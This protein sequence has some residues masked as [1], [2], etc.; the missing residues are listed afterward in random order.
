MEASFGDS[1]FIPGSSQLLAANGPDV[2][3][4]SRQNKFCLPYVYDRGPAVLYPNPTD[5]TRMMALCTLTHIHVHT[6]SLCLYL[7][8][9][10]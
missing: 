7:Q 2:H 1:W 3:Q 6:H 9:H 4:D 5:E 10:A 8:D